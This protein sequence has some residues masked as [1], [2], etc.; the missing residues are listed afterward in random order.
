MEVGIDIGSLTAVALRNVPPGRANYQQRAGRAGRRGSALSTIVTYCGADSHDQEFYSNPAGMVSG[1]VP[2]PTL[3]LDNLEIVRRHCFA[4]VMGMYQMKAIPDPGEADV[5]ANVFESLGTLQDFRRGGIDDFSY[6]GLEAWLRVTADRVSAALKEVVPQPVLDEA[7]D[8]V[9]KIPIEF[10]SILR[11]IGAGPIDPEELK[12]EFSPT[13]EEPNREGGGDAG[14][15][16]DS[17]PMDWGDN[18]EFDAIDDGPAEGPG[19]SNRDAV[20]DSPEGGL[21]PEKLLDRLF[22]RGVLPRYAFPTDVVTFH[23]FDPAASTERKAILKYSPQLGL[24]QA[25]SGYA[26][27]REVWVNGERHYS[28]AIWTPFKRRDC[29]QAW[30]AQKVYF[31]C[32]R[33]GYA[34]VE[35]R[36]HEYYAGQVLDCPACG[37]QGSLG[38]GM[39]WLRP[40]GFAHPIDLDPELPL[41]DSPTPTRP[42]RAKLSAK[43]TD[44]G[45]P[46]SAKSTFND[47]GYEI[48]TAKQR[49][50]LT[51]TGSADETRPGFL[52]CPACGRAEPNGWTAGLL[53][54]GGHP[55]PNPDHHPDGAS[56]RGTYSEVVLGNQFETDIALIRFQLSGSV[57]LPPGSTVARIVLTTVAEALSAAASIL[58]DIEDSEIGAEF[59]VAMTDG[60]RI[61]KQVE[62]YL[63]DL[64]PGGA[65]FVRS[66]ARAPSKLFDKALERLESCTCSHSCYQCLRSYKNKWDHKYFHRGLAAAFIR[67]IVY[68]DIPT[69]SAEADRR[70][71][72][73]LA[74]HLDKSGHKVE[75]I[76][77]GLRM[78]DIDQRV[79]VLGHPLMP[80]EP[81]SAGGRALATSEGPV[82][83]IDQ[84]MIEQALPAAVRKAVGARQ[85]Q[86]AGL[87]LPEFLPELEAGCP[88]YKL[89]SLGPEEPPVPV[90]TVELTAAPE[91]SFVAQL[92]HPTLER[93][94]QGAFV[95]GAWVVFTPTEQDDFSVDNTDQIPR[96]LLKR[97][98]AFKATGE[99]WTLGLPQL[100]EDKIRILY[101]S[102]FAPRAEYPR[103]A[104]VVAFGRVYGVF[105]DGKLRPIGAS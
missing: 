53:R 74:L 23:V 1:P 80:D 40:P 105:I 9:E 83:V 13:A 84:L 11:E 47:A 52:Y 24:N 92:D 15:T 6:A 68:G 94:P 2:D 93:M 103:A 38:L 97:R 66:A 18:P 90:A 42:T 60:G 58:Q 34:R 91:G 78:P 32:D 7:R 20:E 55:R 99:R 100:R 28:F 59:R 86:G 104:E 70:L 35:P 3:N 49:L 45:P 19:Q 65:G 12:G 30:R 75:E 37:T 51:N 82:V 56:C 41:D 43:F 8:F 31:E 26:P 29:W 101:L 4:L 25:L 81:G 67:H 88:V 50:V 85:E 102:Q 22:E 5:S 17:L 62:I 76:Q 36:G 27:G 57:T 96:L 33:C 87:I 98:G 16:L 39:R 10:L 73:E 77:G 63:Y 69:I 48:W 72:H 44:V 89:S 54:K 95:A 79:V 61:G 46:E 14:A 21:D 71:L 64:T